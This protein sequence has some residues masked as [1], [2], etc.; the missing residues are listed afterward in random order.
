MRGSLH[1]FGFKQDKTTLANV[2]KSKIVVRIWEVLEL[3]GTRA[4]LVLLSM[5]RML[6]LVRMGLQPL[7]VS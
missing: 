1:C 5:I 7:P 6:L 4:P 2:N 3:M